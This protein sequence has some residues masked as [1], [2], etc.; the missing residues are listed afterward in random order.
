MHRRRQ[1]MMRVKIGLAAVVGVAAL[2]SWVLAGLIPGGGTKSDC[3]VELNVQG[4]ANPG[5]NVSGSR[6]VSCIDGD[7]CDTDGVCGN[8]ACTLRVA[9]CIDQQDP[10]LPT[11]QPP[12]RLQKLHVNSKLAGAVPSSLE[13]SAC[14][15]FVDLT[16]RSDK[17]RGML[18][19]PAN[20]T[21]PKGTKPRRDRDTFILKCLPRTTPCPT[22]STTTTTTTLSGGGASTTTTV[23]G[24]AMGCTFK[25]GECTG[26]CGPGS[27]CGAAVGTGSCECRRTSCGNA[28]TP[29][30]NGACPS[31]GQ[32]CIFNPIDNACRCVNIP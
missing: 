19:L 11:C 24:I 20:A 8:N 21:A 28:D 6:V 5:S 27:R 2:G 18:R 12:T 32:A 13:G 9:V 30:C 31:A 14:G 23:Q 3:L 29:Q 7:P 25:N 4:V 17:K 10:N 26:S 22:A 15:S 1:M 16:I